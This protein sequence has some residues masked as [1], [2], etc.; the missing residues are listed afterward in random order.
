MITR[1]IGRLIGKNT[2]FIGAGFIIGII[3]IIVITNAT[4]KSS[5]PI[6]PK[7]EQ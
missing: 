6:E 2:L 7:K 1:M 3:L 5:E 4:K